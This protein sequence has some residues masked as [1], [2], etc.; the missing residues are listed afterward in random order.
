MNVNMP[1]AG[2]RSRRPVFL[3]PGQYFAGCGNAHIDTILGS[4]VAVTLWHPPTRCGA[5]CHYMLPGRSPVGQALRDGRYA[6]DA[7][8]LLIAAL[9][10]QGVAA[11]NCHVGLYGGAD[12]LDH[13][14][15]VRLLRV[16]ENNIAAAWELARRHG[17]L[18]TDYNLGGNEYRRLRLDLTDGSVDVTHHPWRVSRPVSE[19]AGETDSRT[20][21][22]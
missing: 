8:D 18:V 4:C 1:R 22:G 5:I 21:G 16:G 20:V 3:Q 14:R 17:L 19:K 10:R 7:L 11:A 12:S 6:E 2:Q 9:R 15:S 13:R